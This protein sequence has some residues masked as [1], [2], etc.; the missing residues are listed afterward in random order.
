MEWGWD[1]ARAILGAGLIIALCWAMSENRKTFPWRLALGAMAVQA[2]LLYL[3]L[4]AS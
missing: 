4:K 2:F 3:P 1:N